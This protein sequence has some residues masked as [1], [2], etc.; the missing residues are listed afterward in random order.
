MTIALVSFACAVAAFVGGLF[1]GKLLM[2]SKL[3]ILEEQLRHQSETT[4]EKIKTLHEAKEAFEKTFDSLSSKALQQ[5]N[6]SFLQLAKTQLQIFQE[7]AKTELDQKKDKISDM[8]KP[9]QESLLKVDQKLELIERSRMQSEAGISQ[10]IKTLIHSQGELRQ[11][12]SSLVSALRSPQTRGQ[13]GEMQLKRVVEMAGMMDHCD[14]VTQST[15]AANGDNRFRPDLVVNLPGGKQ[16]VV[17]AK[18][19]LNSY[20]DGI[21]AEDPAQRKLKFQ[22][23]AKHIRKHIDDLSKKSYWSQFKD[24]PEFVVLFLPGESFFSAALEQEPSLIEVGVTQN[25]ILATPT[26]LIALLRATAYGWQQES[27]AQSIHEVGNLGKELFKRLCDMSGY[28]DRLGRNLN[29]SVDSYNKLVGNV[30]SR[31]MVSAKKLGASGSVGVSRSEQLIVPKK[32][33]ASLRELQNTNNLE[34]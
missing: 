15:T 28:L 33:E 16:I 14:F 26:T 24:S 22:E 10:Q 34:T 19:P 9:V 2:K 31:V 12:T 18:T 20:L 25:V 27:L 5:N 13:W 17:D 4:E 6:E 29:Q 11:E 8:V 7:A 3:Q 30:E 32:I 23:H 21:A 1:L